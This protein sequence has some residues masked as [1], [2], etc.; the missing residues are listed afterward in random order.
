MLSSREQ[1][2]GV[3]YEVL[4]CGGVFKMMFMTLKYHGVITLE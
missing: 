3:C 1:I 2:N 4:F